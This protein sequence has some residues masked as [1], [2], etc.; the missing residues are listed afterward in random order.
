MRPDFHFCVAH[1]RTAPTDAIRPFS[2]NTVPLRT[3]ASVGLTQ[4]VAPSSTNVSAAA[5]MVAMPNKRARIRR[6]QSIVTDRGTVSS[7]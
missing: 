1:P 3:G 6:I 4:I 7:G 2:I 5:T